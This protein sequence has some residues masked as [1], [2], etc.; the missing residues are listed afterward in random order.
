V[1]ARL[2]RILCMLEPGIVQ[3]LFGSGPFFW[4]P[5]KHPFGKVDEECLVVATQMRRFA[6]KIETTV[7]YQLLMSKHPCVVIVNWFVVLPD[8]AW[9]VYLP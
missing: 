2:L 1:C 4:H 7:R 6:F 5:C 3:Q 8:I 9:I